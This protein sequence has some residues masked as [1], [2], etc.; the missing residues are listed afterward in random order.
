MNVVKLAII[1]WKKSSL[2]NG[3]EKDHI[4]R[5]VQIQENP[6]ETSETAIIR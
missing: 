1:K 4:T 2:E 5:M 6:Y 3:E